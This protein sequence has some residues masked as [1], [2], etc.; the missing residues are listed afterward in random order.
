MK[1][2]SQQYTK[3]DPTLPTFSTLHNSL[4]LC[5]RK[6]IV[7]CRKIAREYIELTSLRP[8]NDDNVTTSQELPRRDGPKDVAGLEGRLKFRLRTKSDLFYQVTQYIEDG[9][10][11]RWCAVQSATK[12]N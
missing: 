10:R 11:K 1:F 2:N 5:Q 4:T 8:P 6:Q 7:L 9:S 12:T 3:Q